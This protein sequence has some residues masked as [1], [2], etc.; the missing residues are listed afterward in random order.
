MAGLSGSCG[1]LLVVRPWFMRNRPDAGA[2]VE[3]SELLRQGET[4]EAGGGS[5]F[6]G[7]VVLPASRLQCAL[8]GKGGPHRSSDRLIVRASGVP[9]RRGSSATW[10]AHCQWQ[11]PGGGA[12]RL[13][14]AAAC[15]WPRHGRRQSASGSL[16]LRL[17]AAPRRQ[18][19]LATES[20]SVAGSV[21]RAPG[22]CPG[23]APWQKSGRPRAVA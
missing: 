8:L 23:P 11:R 5:A 22:A 2:T 19:R 18:S 6:R 20:T 1:G 13:Q 10:A 16:S 15:Q 4:G 7:R 14:V 3:A 12:R 9:L 21:Q 17:P